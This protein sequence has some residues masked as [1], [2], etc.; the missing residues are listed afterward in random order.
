MNIRIALA[1]LATAG[2]TF[3]LV[4]ALASADALTVSCSGTPSA[5]AIGWTAST[6]GG[7][8]P[9]AL[10]WGNGSTSSAQSVLYAPGLQN[11]SLQ[12]TDASST[13]ATTTCSATVPW[14][15]PSIS[16]FSAS[17]ATIVAGQNATLSW[18]VANASTTSIAGLPALS[19]TATTV[20]P[21]VTT[22][23]TLTAANPSGTTTATATVSVI[24]SSSTTTPSVLAQIQALLAQIR[25]LQQQIAQL[26]AGVGTPAP[27]NTG[28]TT[29]VSLPV[30]YCIELSRDVRFGDRGDDVRKLQQMLAADPSL[31]ADAQV[32]GYFGEKTLK[33]VMKFQK[34]FGISSATGFV[35]PQTRALFR[36]HCGSGLVT[37]SAS[38]TASTTLTLPPG[39]FKKL[40]DDK[41]RGQDRGRNGRD[42]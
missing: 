36:T 22:T 9:V 17:P 38:S 39:I 37:F 6:S 8:A 1:S 30:R 13:V 27:G 40:D 3:S 33:A 14:P 12:A 25:A 10:L 23:Y 41:G 34:K 32:T 2:M 15:L 18:S 5:N 11:I 20:S 4:P 7:V 28:T 19:G 21:A 16:L 35:G 42:D 29:P 24:P 31:F 26:V